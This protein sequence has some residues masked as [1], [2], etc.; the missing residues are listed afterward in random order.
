MPLLPG[1]RAR[2]PY[3]KPQ[4][5]ARGKNFQR[6]VSYCSAVRWQQFFQGLSP[7]EQLPAEGW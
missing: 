2:D 7:R 6:A 1:E 3:A 4:E 5:P